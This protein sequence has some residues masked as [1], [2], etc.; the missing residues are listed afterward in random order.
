MNHRAVFLIGAL[1]L[2]SCGGRSV[3]S[4]LPQVPQSQCAPVASYDDPK[5][6]VRDDA[7][8]PIP[9]THALRTQ[10]AS[11][12]P[13]VAAHAPELLYHGGTVQ[14]TPSI[15]VVF[16]GFRTHGDP[17]GEA[18]RLGAFM[19]A[20]GASAWLNTVTQYYQSGPR[21]IANPSR[22]L[23]GTWYDDTDPVPLHPSDAN[24][25]S[26]A[27]R[28]AQ[29]FGGAN[30]EAAYI[31]ATPN[32]H[33]I[34]GFP[35][36]YCAYHGDTDGGRVAYTNLPYM[37]NGG[38]ACGANAVN[39]GAAGKLDGVTIIAGHELAETQTDPTGGGW[40]DAYGNE[41]GDKCAWRNLR[42]TNFGSFGTFP[43]QPLYSNAAHVCMQ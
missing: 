4:A 40:Y 28:A 21:F 7:M 10:D 1:A 27:T 31:V 36:N 32:G 17:Y 5:F 16:W 19:N 39:A 14:T 35:R 38:Y 8:N 23:A 18:T 43:T 12:S 29:H 37:P 15:Y 33:N 42:D 2:A 6:A 20:L 25:R 22:Q 41:I 34:A 30:A 9:H 13:C 26:E 11:F 3:T 24:V